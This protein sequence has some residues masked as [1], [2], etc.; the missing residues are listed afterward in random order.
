MTNDFYDKSE[1]HHL[2][3]PVIRVT[4]E[5][6]NGGL[7]DLSV[8]PK[9]SVHVKETVLNGDGTNSFKG[10]YRYDG[11]SLFDILN[12]I[13]P[14][15]SNRAEFNSVIDLF[16]VVENPDGE[17]VVFSWG[18]IFYPVNLH[19]IIVATDVSRII[20]TKTGD[21]WPL[22]ATP[23]IVAANDLLTERNISIPERITILSFRRSFNVD[24][25]TVPHY[26][27]FISIYEWGNSAFRI[28]DPG[29]DKTSVTYNTIF[30]GRG[31]GIHSTK[32]FTGIMLKDALKDQFH[33]NRENL[34]QGLFCIAGTDGY[35]CVLS[36]S[37]LF[38]R[39]DQQEFLL[40][41]CGDREGGRFRIFPASDFFS[42]RAV[43]S[44]SEI[45]FDS[46]HLS[47]TKSI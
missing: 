22:P 24:R 12:T 9:R 46:Q 41:E 2:G 4:G 38:N 27:P 47:Y 11:Y 35:R 20:P 45:H 30:Y 15:K 21:L 3:L 8:L 44:V 37:E 14:E 43:K 32:P 42:D 19:R 23:M 18:E 34:R 5:A 1:T 13:I 26:S 31:R 29:N 33:L 7:T 17:K 25:S 40:V 36:Y 10:A 39:N 28:A 6:A 16:V